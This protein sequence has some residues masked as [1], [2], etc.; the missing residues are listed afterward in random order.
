[1]RDKHLLLI[2]LILF[3]ILIKFSPFVFGAVIIGFY[4]SIVIDVPANYLS[5]KLNKRL[6]KVISYTLILSLIFYSVVN[7]IPTIINEGKN[8]FLELSKI[9]ITDSDKLPSWLLDFLNN[10]NKEISNFALGLINNLISYMPSI[11]T[12]TII[13]IITTVAISNLKEYLKK[14]VKYFFVEDPKKGYS[15]LRSFYKDFEKFV[16]GQVLVAVFVGILVGLLSFLFG[17]KGSFFLGVL[18]FI[19]DFIPFLG[20]VIVSI[21]MLMLGWVSKGFWGI[22]ISVI[23]LVAVNQIESWILAPKIQSNNLKIHWFVLIISLLVFND[24]FGFLGILLAIPIILFVKRY[25]KS[26]V[27]GG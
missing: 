2:Y 18:S 22:I 21:P 7:F 24:F 12:M 27:I 13:I 17:I 20:V 8:I 5:K 9:S 11:I 16:S 23:I 15:F 6:S 14:N 4:F 26:Y 1:M 25:W 3:L 10:S 19:T